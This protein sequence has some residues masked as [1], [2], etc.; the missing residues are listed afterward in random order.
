[1]SEE[2]GGLSVAAALIVVPRVT[3]SEAARANREAV[4]SEEY[5]RT[6]WNHAVDAK[7]IVDAQGVIRDVNRR[8]EFKLGRTRAELIDTP[9]VNLFWDH[10]RARFRRVLTQAVTGG[11]ERFTSGLH[12]PT[13]SGTILT[14]DLD[15]V[16]VQR[17][18]GVI[19]VLLQFADMTEK[20]QLE[21]QLIRSERLASLSQ[22]ASMFAH[23]I[24][25]P[26]AGIKKTLELLKERPELHAQPIAQWF[27][28]L[29]QTTDFLLGMI[30]DMLDV[31]QESYSGLPIVVSHFAVG[32]LFQ[33]AVHLFKS[34][35]D[36]KGV[37]VRLDVCPEDIT[38]TGDRRRLQRVGINL[39]HNALK[40]S[41]PKGV[42][43]I[44]I[45]AGHEGA[46]PAGLG[47]I[48][49]DVLLMRVEDEG[50]GIAAEDLPS[51]F[52]MFFRK[53]DG[54]DLRIGRGLG[55]HFCRLVIEAH[56]GRI[57]AANRSSGGAQF[58]IA[59]P[60]NAQG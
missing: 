14:M 18:D 13:L 33:E 48:G 55:L 45:K 57:W 23:D 42:I 43:T 1:M 37:T 4:T 49:D 12:V 59:V 26:L 30:N 19:T 35:A 51:L 29:Q 15:I 27:G 34:E 11:K 47:S 5:Y 16:P 28:D 44:S 60:L 36:A 52:E 21:Q 50:P 8:T 7:V 58:S 40:Y 46:M 25:N 20:R 38:M 17:T 56:H 3:M 41:P 24:R 54:H 39:L 53:K 22:F 2:R 10:D 9:V 32:A 6:L 31:Y